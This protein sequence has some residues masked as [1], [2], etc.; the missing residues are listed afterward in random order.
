VIAIILGGLGLLGS[1][2][3]IAGLAAGPRLQQS[4]TMQPQGPGSDKVIEVQ[5]T[6]QQKI[7]A[8]TDRYWW[9]NAGFALVNLGL[10]AS[11]VT[12]GIMVL[13][14]A[15]R[16]RTLLMAVFAVAILFEISRSV[17]QG[18]MQWEM[19]GVMSDVLPRMMGAS[20]PANGPGAQQAA[21]MAA[22]IGK[23]SIIAGV[24][25]SLIFSA[26]KLIYYAV[27]WSYLRRPAAGQWLE[28][29]GE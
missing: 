23:A 21:A 20:A 6:M 2:V 13:N 15:A 27:G 17:V 18:F 8:V 9:P 28:N 29:A 1:L 12:G 26:A 22:A 25:F 3:A 24:A 14:R 10:A 19:A 7:Q 4:L 5:R 11:M 16:A